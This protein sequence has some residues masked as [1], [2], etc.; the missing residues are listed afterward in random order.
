MGATIHRYAVSSRLAQCA[1][2]GILMAS[3]ASAQQTTSPAN[4]ERSADALERRLEALERRAGEWRT[5]DSV[6]HLA[7]YADA[8]Y[9]DRSG[10]E[11]GFD[12]SRSPC[13]YSIRCGKCG[14][15]GRPELTS[16]AGAAP[17]SLQYESPGRSAV[18]HATQ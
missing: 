6:F 13:R 7:G 5:R 15:R 3:A 4:E 17:P 12:P 8:G 10:G 16:D 2:L 9:A 18:A 1:A 14:A 11:S